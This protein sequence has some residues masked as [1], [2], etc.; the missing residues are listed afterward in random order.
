M[1]PHAS[2][3][4]RTHLLEGDL[5]IVGRMPY[6]SNTTLL[7]E[8]CHDGQ[9]SNAVYK[10]GRGE[11]PLWD[12]PPDVF[13]REV[14]AY[15]LAL[16]LGWGV[17]PTTVRR[18]GPLGDGSVQQLIDADF[19][20][21]YFTLVE[22]DALRP[23]LERICLFDLLANNTDRK[24]GHCLV[25]GPG[26]ARPPDEE[27]EGSHLWGIDNALCFHAEFKLRTVM[28]DFAGDPM[29]TGLLAD[30]DDFLADDLPDPLVELLDPIER[31]A[32]RARATAARR[33][34]VFPHDPTGRRYPWPMV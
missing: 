15:E 1:H 6:S 21:H 27:G 34:G 11:R 23:Q 5:E 9:T 25:S 32:L 30:I 33:E 26:G 10:P 14:A 7:V 13:K 22:R 29:P 12:F 8:V 19:D 2:P 16:A 31:D 28:W 4:L 20:Q 18:D 24:G 3:E 17:V